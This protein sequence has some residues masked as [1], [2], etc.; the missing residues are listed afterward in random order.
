MTLTKKNKFNVGTC[1]IT[2]SIL[3]RQMFEG[4][5]SSSMYWVYSQNHHI[6]SHFW[7]SKLQRIWRSNSYI[8]REL[9]LQTNGCHFYF[10]FYLCLFLWGRWGISGAR[11]WPGHNKLLWSA[12]LPHKAL[13]GCYVDGP[14]GL[15]TS[16]PGSR[17]TLWF[18]RCNYRDGEHGRAGMDV[19]GRKSSVFV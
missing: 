13:S 8:F 1:C 14:V 17:S 10:S 18:S 4:L 19:Q 6:R 2:S 9:M 11:R 7:P 12:G 5:I 15:A 16:P 3:T